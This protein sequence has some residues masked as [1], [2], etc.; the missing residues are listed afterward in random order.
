[1][2]NLDRIKNKVKKKEFFFGS[3]VNLADP[4][5][6]EI[7]CEVGFEFI[8]IEI[9]HSSLDK[10]MTQLHIMLTKGSKAATF[11]R[12]PDTNPA[13]VKPLLDMG[14]SGIIFPL[15]K[16]ADDAKLAV[17]SCRYPTKGIR[18]FGP[19]RVMRYGLMD[20]YEYIKNADSNIWVM[21]MIEHV[22]AVKNLDEILKVPGVDSL[23]IGPCDLSGSVGLL[24]QLRHKKVENLIDIVIKKSKAANI[25]V[26]VSM[27]YSIDEVKRWLN[28]G[29]DWMEL[30]GDLDF[31]T[32]SAANCVKDVKSLLNNRIKK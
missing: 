29:I 16:N 26:G 24:G 23:V 21:L 1:M 22:D 27:A 15:I 9:E 5:V 3:G 17:K 14:P 11:I 30:G 31:L 28:K 25:P 2:N 32:W 7:L 6:T 20:K 19:R 13:T 4:T 18:G 12:V 8:W 10:Y